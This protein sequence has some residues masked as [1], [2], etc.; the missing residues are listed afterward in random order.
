MQW[1]I[2]TLEGIHFHSQGEKWFPHAS[3]IDG[4]YYSFTSLKGTISPT[5]MRGCIVMCNLP[6]NQLKKRWVLKIMEMEKKTPGEICFVTHKNP[7]NPMEG[8]FN[9]LQSYM[10]HKIFMIIIDQKYLW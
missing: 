7:S 2:F 5:E 10:I 8:I 4:K 6:T 1:N 3:V 9:L